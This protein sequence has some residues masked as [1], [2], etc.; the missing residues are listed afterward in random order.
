MNNVNHRRKAL[1]VGILGASALL[2]AEGTMAQDD[3][4]NLGIEEMVVTAQKREENV[5]AVPISISTL[6]ANDIERR[7]VQSAADL[8]STVPNMAGFQ[9]PGARG[10]ASIAMRGVTSGSP[11]NLS[12]DSSIGIYIDGFFLGKPLSAGMDVAE[13]ERIEVLRGP[14]GNSAVR[15]AV[16]WA[17]TAF[18][19]SRLR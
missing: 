11:A 2:L 16:P 19:A 8:M 6:S 1:F 12:I 14:Q 15:S 3:V 5:Q 4:T 18:G 17:A 13:L 7:G 10:N 9:S